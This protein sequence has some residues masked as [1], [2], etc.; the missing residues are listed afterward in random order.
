MDPRTG[1]RALVLDMDGVIV[2]SEPIH[3]RADLAVFRS[4]G[5][6]VPL[7][8]L[9]GYAG[10]GGDTFFRSVL[11]RFGLTGDPAS[12]RAEKNRVLAGILREETPPVPGILELLDRAE[13]A[14]FRLAVAS[15]TDD[16][17]VDLVLGRLGIRGR[18]EAVIG[19]TRVA[20]GKPAPDIFL[21]AARALRLP[22][23]RCVVVE[24]STAGTRAARAAGMPC[25]GLRNPNSGL[26]DLSA[27]SCSADSLDEIGAELLLALLDRPGE[28]P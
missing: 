7:S 2:D 21:E 23:S 4:I 26:Q 12:L 16:A 18:F 28:H 17:I 24:D 25:V 22:P 15:S 6:D 10:V 27:A 3:K 9:Q 20:R 11:E 8:V 19:G 1:D 5:L 13:S 14:G